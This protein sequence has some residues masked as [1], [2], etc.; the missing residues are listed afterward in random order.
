MSKDV[1][2]LLQI[3]PS[4]LD[5]INKILADPD[6]QI[7]NDFLAVVARYGTPEEINAKAEAANQITALRDKVSKIQPDYLSDLD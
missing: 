5:A 6:M 1:R 7:I 4:R 3:P 2:A